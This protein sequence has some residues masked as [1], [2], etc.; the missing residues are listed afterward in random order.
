MAS[1]ADRKAPE[2]N[3]EFRE[4][5]RRTNDDAP[6]ACGPAAMVSEFRQPPYGNLN[7]W[8]APGAKARAGGRRRP[9]ARRDPRQCSACQK[10]LQQMPVADCQSGEP[11]PKSNR[12]NSVRPRQQRRIDGIAERAGITWMTTDA[13]NSSPAGKRSE[14]P[15]AEACDERWIR[16]HDATNMVRPVVIGTG[17]QIGRSHSPRSGARPAAPGKNL[18]LQLQAAQAQRYRPL[19]EPAPSP[20]QQ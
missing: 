7:R 1:R 2:R 5:L 6:P 14:R 4:V 15:A 12:A 8:P 20:R 3:S 9:V 19:T 13:T 18:G 17:R 16:Q 10:K 11:P